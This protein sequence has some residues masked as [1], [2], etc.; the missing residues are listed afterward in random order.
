MNHLMIC[1]AGRQNQVMRQHSQNISM[2]RITRLQRKQRARTEV[3]QK[4]TVKA[5][6]VQ[7]TRML[8]RQQ[9][10][11]LAVQKRMKDQTLQ[12][13]QAVTAVRQAIIRLRHSLHY[14]VM[15]IRKNVIRPSASVVP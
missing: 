9:V 11:R 1:P 2:I 4:K 3:P 5:Q 7:K 15:W 13:V 10:L 6:Q 12:A 8:R 14:C